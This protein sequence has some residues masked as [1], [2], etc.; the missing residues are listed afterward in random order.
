MTIPRILVAEDEEI[1]RI[2]VLDHLR[3]QGWLADDAATGTPGAGAG[4]SRTATSCSSPTSACPGWTANGCWPR[5]SVWRRAPK[6]S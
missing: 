1:M 5:S 2:T 4:E 6:W 3:R